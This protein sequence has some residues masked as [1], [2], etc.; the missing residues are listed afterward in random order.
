MGRN[1]NFWPFTIASVKWSFMYGSIIT[2][3]RLCNTTNDQNSQNVLCWWVSAE[4]HMVLFRLVPSVCYMSAFVYAYLCVWLLT[5][6]LT[7][8][9]TK[10]SSL[11]SPLT[12]K[13]NHWH[14]STRPNQTK[15]NP[16][17]PRSVLEW[18]EAR[19]A[20]VGRAFAL[21]ECTVPH[22][23][24]HYFITTCL[25]FLQAKVRPAFQW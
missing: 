12:E 8:A 17:V 3:G 10:I 19:C 18:I 11:C 13:N 24:Q 15:P 14:Q 16:S 23:H 4:A 5:C 6:N 21:C 25:T 20:E 22:M 9:E 1:W 7:A 2:A